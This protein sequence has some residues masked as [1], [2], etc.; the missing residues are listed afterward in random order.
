VTYELAWNGQMMLSTSE[1]HG[2]LSGLSINPI[3]QNYAWVRAVAPDG[4]RSAPSDF[5]LVATPGK[6]V[7]GAVAHAR[8]TGRNPH[9]LSIAWDP[10]PD[11]GELAG[12]DVLAPGQPVKVQISARDID[13]RSGPKVTLE[14]STAPLAPVDLAAPAHLRITASLLTWDAAAG[15]TA[16]RLWRDG[17]AGPGRVTDTSVP[18]PPGDAD[19]FVQVSALDNAG[20]ASPRSA[21]LPL[22]HPGIPAAPIL[23]AG[24]RSGD[25]VVLRW[26]RPAAGTCIGYR[27]EQEQT[28][29]SWKAI[30]RI[31]DPWQDT[32]TVGP[33][34]AFQAGSR[35]CLPVPG[36]SPDAAL[37]PGATYRFRV[38][39]LAPD[40][41][42]VT[43]AT[44][45]LTTVAPPA[46]NPRL[47]FAVIVATDGRYDY[48]EHSLADADAANC[49]FA[50]IKGQIVPQICS[51]PKQ[52]DALMAVVRRHK[53]PSI[54]ALLASKDGWCELSDDITSGADDTLPLWGRYDMATWRTGQPFDQTRTELGGALRVASALENPRSNPAFLPDLERSL[55]DADADDAC[56]WFFTAG[57]STESAPQGIPRIMLELYR[58][59]VDFMR[60]INGDRG[61]ELAQDP[62]SAVVCACPQRGRV[63][64]H[65]LVTVE[66]RRLVIEARQF[67][68]K[69]RVVVTDGLQEIACDRAA[70]RITAA[71]LRVPYPF[72]II[73]G[74]PERADHVPPWTQNRIIACAVG[75]RAEVR[76][77]G[78]SA[79]QAPLHFTIT[80]AP[81]HGK[82]AGTDDHFTYE[83]DPG[84][85]GEDLFLYRADDDGPWPGN[86][87]W[88]RL[89][90]GK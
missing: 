11:D 10:A 89:N 77:L 7:P 45:A 66:D 61:H 64:A 88:V 12:Y 39:A 62:G 48:L 44:L 53:T 2:S 8:V 37:Q 83:P 50:L 59:G 84:F 9:G 67:D 1:T 74:L 57:V 68:K 6:T 5:V 51:D 3:P 28:P 46:P 75:G 55:Q 76:L 79:R 80:R 35:D 40:G 81:L 42:E 27:V 73:T 60:M 41:S 52:W 25:L 15:A 14:D 47:R 13:D 63:G 58:P 71:N 32:Y 90:V 24:G 26:S 36:A 16:Y 69:T 78:H 18:L 65:Y 49:A 20:N 21:A 87:A 38:V 29:G 85:S 70:N 4:T 33:K 72:G 23:S 19:G 86:T 30:A 54:L 31:D 43:G 82:L 22:G 56:R 17:M 34:D